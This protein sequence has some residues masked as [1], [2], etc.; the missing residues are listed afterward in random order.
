MKRARL[1]EMLGTVLVLGSVI[2]CAAGS[3]RWPW[4]FLG[5]LAVFLA[6]RFSD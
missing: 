3:M 1:L 4:F 5:G 6:G 2:G